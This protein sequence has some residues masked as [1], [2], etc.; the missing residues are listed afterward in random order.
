VQYLL[1][2]CCSHDGTV[3]AATF[4]MQNKVMIVELFSVCWSTGLCEQCSVSF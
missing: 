2:T 4:H 1:R 3:A